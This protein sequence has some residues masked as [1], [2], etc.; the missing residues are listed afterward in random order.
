MNSLLRLHNLFITSLASIYEPI[1]VPH[2]GGVKWV[3][4]ASQ[5]HLVKQFEQSLLPSERLRGVGPENTPRI[6]GRT[7]VRPA[8]MCPISRFPLGQAFSVQSPNDSLSPK[9]LQNERPDDHQIMDE[10]LH[11][12]DC[13]KRI[14]VH[15]GA[16]AA[17]QATGYK[18]TDCVE[19]GR[20][21]ALRNRFIERC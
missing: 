20:G 1:F 17:K 15:R 5:Q 13:R 9:S 10:C 4:A 6:R 14:S 11:N 12:V 3:H 8:S 18:S 7:C 2:F 21:R 16:I 19:R